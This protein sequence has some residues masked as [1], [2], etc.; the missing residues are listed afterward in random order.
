M[1]RLPPLLAF[2]T[3]PALAAAPPAPQVRA[4]S[5]DDLAKP[6]PLPYSEGADADAAAAAAKALA[7]A[8][9]KRLL[10]DLGGSWYLDCRLSAGAIDPPELRGYVNRHHEVVTVDVGRVTRNG[11]IPACYGVTGRLA[12]APAVLVTDPRTG[13]LINRSDGTAL[14]DARSLSPEAVADR[15]V[16]WAA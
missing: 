9:H 15:L 2:A 6:L 10:I 4:H 8:A 5:F 11:P 16:Q 1:K 7:L 13:R 12:C 3:V 14:G